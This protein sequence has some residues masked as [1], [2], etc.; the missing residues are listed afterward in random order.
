MVVVVV[1]MVGDD[2]QGSGR[3]GGACGGD[4]DDTVH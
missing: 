1:G 2:D 3:A 4:A